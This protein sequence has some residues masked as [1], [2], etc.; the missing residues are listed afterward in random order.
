[1]ATK[2]GQMETANLSIMVSLWAVFKQKCLQEFLILFFLV[3][4]ETLELTNYLLYFL[5]FI[6][7]TWL[8]ILKTCICE[9]TPNAESHELL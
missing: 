3:A 2:Y 4:S 5:L 8:F 1:M 9:F 7:Y 6:Y